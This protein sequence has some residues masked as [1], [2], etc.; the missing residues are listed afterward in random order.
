MKLAQTL[1][2]TLQV[3]ASPQGLW[4]CVACVGVGISLWTAV[5]ARDVSA[6]SPPR[7]NSVPAGAEG[8]PRKG[9]GGPLSLAGSGSNVML[10]REVVAQCQRAG[11]QL[12][13]V[14]EPGIGSSSGLRAALVSRALASSELAPGEVYAPYARSPVAF[15]SSSKPL[16]QLDTADLL[17]ALA[18]DRPQWPD[19]RP[20]H[21][22]LREPGDSGHRILAREFKG[23]ADVEGRARAQQAAPVYFHDRTLHAALLVSDESVGIV[24]ASAV[25]AEG[26]PLHFFYRGTTEPTAEHVANGTWSLV[27]PHVLVYPATEA[28]KLSGLLSCLRSAAGQETLRRFGA[29]PTLQ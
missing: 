29:A 20:L 27:K 9:L 11:Q 1:L 13:V 14:V 15:A 24:D 12:S 17:A 23:F 10:L 22:A 21:W 28:K 7:P 25:R 8:R 2:S 26:L 4:G 19:G 6:D 5:L 18:V 16:A 3:I